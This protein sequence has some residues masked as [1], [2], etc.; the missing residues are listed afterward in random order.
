MKRKSILHNLQKHLFTFLQFLISNKDLDDN[1][2]HLSD[3][4]SDCV[5]RIFELVKRKKRKT[6]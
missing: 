5:R 1:L 6:K 3:D 4:I 2:N